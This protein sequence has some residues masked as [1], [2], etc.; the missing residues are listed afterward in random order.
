MKPRLRTW[1]AFENVEVSPN[2]VFEDSKGTVTLTIPA[3]YAAII[4]GALGRMPGTKYLRNGDSIVMSSLY[5]SLFSQLK[6]IGLGG[7]ADPYANYGRDIVKPGDARPNYMAPPNQ[8][9]AA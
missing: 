5:D 6:K 9:K 4:M 1:S 2:S 8:R 7:N 3:E